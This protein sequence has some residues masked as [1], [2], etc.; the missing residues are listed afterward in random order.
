[1]TVLSVVGAV[2]QSH[3]FKRNFAFDLCEE[4]V[5]N[6][7]AQKLNTHQLQFALLKQ[8]KD[9]D[10]LRRGRQDI[11]A[12]ILLYC[13]QQ[14]TKTS[15]MYNT[16]LNY[17]QLKKQMRLLTAQQLLERKINKYQTTEKGLHYIEL[18]AQLNELLT[19][20]IP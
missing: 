16:N 18:Y 14:K 7:E 13:E 10:T 9:S 17:A 11:I 1:M 15:I 19:K 8:G 5:L 20:T 12:E 6:S 3:S 2:W 4:N